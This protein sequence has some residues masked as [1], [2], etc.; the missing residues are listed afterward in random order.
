[1]K[2]RL[3]LKPLLE[4][5]LSEQYLVWMNDPGVVKYTESRW[6]KY[7]MSDL[8]SFVQDMNKSQKD[9]LFGIFIAEN[10][11]HIGNIKIGNI[12]T[13]HSY[14]ELGIIIGIKE[15]W[16]KGYASEALKLAIEYAFDQLKLYKL[17]ADVYENNIGSIKALQ[18]VGFRE[19]GRYADHCRFADDRVDYLLFE[20]I[21]TR[22]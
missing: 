8:K 1:M 17:I 10:N 21:K 13:Q 12:N 4:D 9:Y 6:T 20:V 11:F 16:G 22:G 14:A 7:T 19:C 2:N 5:S 18:K 3:I 15:E